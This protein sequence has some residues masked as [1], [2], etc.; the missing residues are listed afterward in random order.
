MKKL[1]FK[2]VMQK[3]PLN[4][5]LI[6]CSKYFTFKHL[7]NEY[8]IKRGYFEPRWS[9]L[10]VVSHSSLITN[11]LVLICDF[12][13]NINLHSS[14]GWILLKIKVWGLKKI[15]KY[16]QRHYLHKN[17]GS[18]SNFFQTWNF[19]L[20]QFCSHLR[21]V[22]VLDLYWKSWTRNTRF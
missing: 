20:W 22:S 17:R 9:N 18:N 8:C 6:K 15:E 4:E 3:F 19:D 10:T 5:I 12:Q 14:R 1:C 13:L 21:Y 7:L 2:G 11:Q 16:S